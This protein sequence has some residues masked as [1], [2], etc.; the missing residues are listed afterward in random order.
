MQPPRSLGSLRVLQRTLAE[1]TRESI[2][3]FRSSGLPAERWTMVSHYATHDPEDPRLERR[4]TFEVTQSVV[5][6]E[7]HVLHGIIDCIVRHP[8]ST[9]AAPDE[10][11]VLGVNLS[12]GHGCRKRTFGFR[13]LETRLCRQ[14][15]A[16]VVC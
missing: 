7:K 11:E 14:R 12:K 2:Q 3:R 8:E 9:H 13:A 6:H 1:R 15:R 10:I 5:H 4:S 16:H